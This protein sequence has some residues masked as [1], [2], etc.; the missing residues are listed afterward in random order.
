MS[1]IKENVFP[2]SENVPAMSPAAIKSPLSV[3]KSPIAQTKG[4][5]DSS[6]TPNSPPVDQHSQAP[7]S[8]VRSGSGDAT[9]GTKRS[10]TGN[11]IQ[12]DVASPF[13]RC[14]RPLESLSPNAR[15][16]SAVPESFAL[17]FPAMDPINDDDADEDDE[18]EDAV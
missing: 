17:P 12:D 15:V 10:S 8:A 6:D 3:G 5:P 7:D 4:K 11:R 18:S 16:G 2:G 13:E 14:V 1:A 9:C